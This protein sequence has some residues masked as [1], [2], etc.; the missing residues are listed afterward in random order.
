[1]AARHPLRVEILRRMISVGGPLSPIELSKELDEKLPDVSYHVRK[2]RD[3]G[4]IEM[5]DEKDRR[6]ATQHFYEVEPSWRDDRLVGLLL[7][8]DS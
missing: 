2:L 8:G 5:V 6:G 7:A 3:V 1:M 4:A